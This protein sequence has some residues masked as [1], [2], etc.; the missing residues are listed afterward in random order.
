[1]HLVIPTALEAWIGGYMGPSYKVLLD[2]EQITYSIFRQA[3]ALHSEDIL[4]PGPAQWRS[5]LRRIDGI[6]VWTWSPEYVGNVE[7]TPPSERTSWSLTIKHGVR[8]VSS[9]GE[10]VFAPGFVEYL[11]AVRDLLGGRNFA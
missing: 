8:E 6:G 5:F 9:K 11:R 1:M 4:V 10:G 2:G 7:D 3:Y